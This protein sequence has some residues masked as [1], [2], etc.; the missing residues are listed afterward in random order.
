[1]SVV[2]EHQEL[3]TKKYKAPTVSEV[4]VWGVN[5]INSKYFSVWLICPIGVSLCV[6]DSF[7]CAEV[8]CLKIQV[9]W[10]EGLFR[11]MYK[12]SVGCILYEDVDVA[13]GHSD[14]KNHMSEVPIPLDWLG[15]VVKH[16]AVISQ[17]GTLDLDVWGWWMI[18]YEPWQV[19]MVWSL[20]RSRSELCNQTVKST[21]TELCFLWCIGTLLCAVHFWLNCCPQAPSE[22]RKLQILELKYKQPCEIM[23]AVWILIFWN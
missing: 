23:E 3:V 2:K 6:K 17:G 20:S 19:K 22:H 21:G 12:L 18:N 11:E 10:D 9:L 7:S 13:D 8:T 1:M 15:I 4:F 14:Q 16:C 5:M